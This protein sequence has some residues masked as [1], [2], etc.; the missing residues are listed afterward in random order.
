MNEI[1]DRF[2]YK[3]QVCLIIN[4]MNLIKQKLVQ[5]IENLGSC[6]F[7]NNCNNLKH[8]LSSSD[9][10]ETIYSV[11]HELYRDYT[12]VNN[13]DYQ[14]LTVT[15]KAKQCLINMLKSEP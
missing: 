7:E 4:T 1:W 10:L 12:N 11:L 9:E 14:Y 8:I 6:L 5:C 2:D 13:I 3:K 15:E